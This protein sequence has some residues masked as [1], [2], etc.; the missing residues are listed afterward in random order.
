VTHGKLAETDLL[1]PVLTLFPEQNYW[2]VQQVALGRKK[3]DLVC[4]E[5]DSPHGTQSIEL[6]I[7]DWRKAL[8]QASINF[9]LSEKSYIAI[10]HE[11]VHRVLRHSDLLST[12]GVG[13]I[14][15]YPCEA[16]ILSESVDLVRRLSR[17]AKRD[18]YK[19]LIECR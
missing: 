18:W 16:E 17:D 9:Q 11:Y 3:I 10:W 6:K 12:Y 4:I 1:T 8:W 7:Q 14:A 15:V 13:L 5:R 2:H 19:H